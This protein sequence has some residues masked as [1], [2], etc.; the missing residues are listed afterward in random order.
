VKIRHRKQFRFPFCY[1]IFPVF[2]LTLGTMAIAA[3]VVTYS[4]ISTTIASINMAAQSRSSALFVWKVVQFE[5]KSMWYQYFRD[6][7][8]F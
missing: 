6:P 4:K 8:D 2:T 1:P 3:R 5:D 7:R